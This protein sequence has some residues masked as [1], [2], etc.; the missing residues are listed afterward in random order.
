MVL[1]IHTCSEEVKIAAL[2]CLADKKSGEKSN[3]QP[4]FV[5]QK[6]VHLIRLRTTGNTCLETFKDFPQMHQFTLRDEGEI[7]AIGKVWKLVPDND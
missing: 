3:T 1:H 5:R 2:I 4:Y 6:Q 7:I